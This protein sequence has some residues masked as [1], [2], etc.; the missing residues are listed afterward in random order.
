MSKSIHDHHDHQR[1]ADNYFL[2][3]AMWLRVRNSLAFVSLAGWLA[4]AAGFF[5]D[6]TQFQFSYLVA[7]LFFTSIALGAMFYVMV[8]HLT[9]SAWSVTVRRLME[10][11]MRVLP[12]ALPLF[13]PIVLGL[14]YT[15]RVD[16]RRRCERP[17]PLPEARLPERNLV[18]DPRR[19]RH[20]AVEPV[21]V[22][23]VQHLTR[24]GRRQI[25]ASHRPR[26]ALE[27]SRPV[28]ALHHRLHRLLST[29]SCRSIRT[30]IRRCSASTS[31]PAG[32]WHS[33]RC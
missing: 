8:Q 19:N 26:A 10:N 24:A 32:R 21:V 13:I 3:P 23:V 33:C 18:R 4:L 7:F 16:P 31:S 6:R 9:G 20:R 11:M 28:D 15:L 30:G 1:Q 29:G 27:R 17:D 22:E 2:A 25:A 5:M 14:H 12:L